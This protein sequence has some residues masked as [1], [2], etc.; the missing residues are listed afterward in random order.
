MENLCKPAG[1]RRI[2]RA[3]RASRHDVGSNAARK[4]HGAS[5][6]Y[7]LI[8]E[9]EAAYG[10]SLLRTTTRCGGTATLVGTVR[11]AREQLARGASWAGLIV[12]VPLPDGLG[13]DLLGE[14]RAKG[15]D[16]PALITSGLRDNAVAHAAFGLGALYLVKP[17]DD[18]Y[19]ESFLRQ[20]S[21]QSASVHTGSRIQSVIANWTTRFGLS[22]AERSILL[23]S[24][25][26]Y[27]RAAIATI[28]GTSEATVKNQIC[29]LFHKTG[30]LC[31]LEA[32]VRMLRETLGT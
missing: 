1:S 8:V 7:I 28:R 2:P 13:L 4:G 6:V 10:R 14:A 25:E 22:E 20:A 16:V 3:K 17:V 9:D 26:G 12:D 24:A 11:E 30:D 5:C 18:V 15:L 32:V 31:L 19:I 21:L 29:S 27:D 23:L